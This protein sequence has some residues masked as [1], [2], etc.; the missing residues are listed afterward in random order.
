[1]NGA[2]PLLS[3][4]PFMAWSLKTLLYSFNLA[5]Y[6]ILTYL[7]EGMKSVDGISYLDDSNLDSPFLKFERGHP[8]VYYQ[9]CIIYYAPSIHNIYQ[10]RSNNYN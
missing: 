8:V 7:K 1:M 6:H 3:L 2:V 4:F 5:V 9:I 10:T